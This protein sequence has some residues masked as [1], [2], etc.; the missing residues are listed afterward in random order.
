MRLRRM[1]HPLRSCV[2]TEIRFVAQRMGHPGSVALGAAE[3]D[4]GVLR[5]GVEQGD[6]DWVADVHARLTSN[7]LALDRWIEDADEDAFAAHSGDDSMEALS[8]AAR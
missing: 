8:N 2:F 3:V 7:D 6:V 1:T 4:E 5:V